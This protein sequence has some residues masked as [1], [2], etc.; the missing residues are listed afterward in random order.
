MGI[1]HRPE[2]PHRCM[3]GW[4]SIP[5]VYD[6]PTGTVWQCDDCGQTWVSQGRRGVGDFSVSFCRESRRAKRRRDLDAAMRRHPAGKKKA[7]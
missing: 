7:P 6:Y 3:P 1:L 2:Q 4:P 5:L